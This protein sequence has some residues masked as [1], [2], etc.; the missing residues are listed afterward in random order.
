MTFYRLFEEARKGGEAKAVRD[1]LVKK[2]PKK[3][4][5]HS[6]GTRIKNAGNVSSEEFRKDLEEILN[7]LELEFSNTEIIP[8][9]RNLSSKA[10][11][12]S[13]DT[14]HVNLS[15]SSRK[16]FGIILA[17][18]SGRTKTSTL[19]K[20]GMV[21]FFF[22]SENQYEPFNKRISDS[23]EEYISLLER[24]IADI[25]K[26]GINGLEKKDAKEIQE[27]LRNKLSEYDVNIL[28]SI[29]NAMS[30]GNW[31]RNSQFS[32]YEIRRDKIFSDIKKAGAK[33]TKIPEDKW[34]PM[35][36]ML[37]EKGKESEVRSTIAEV[38]AEDNKDTALSK[39]NRLFIN[40]ID[41]EG[42]DDKAIC[43]AVSLKEAS[44]Q[45]GRAKSYIDSLDVS[46]KTHYNLSDQEKSWRENPEKILKEIIQQREEIQ[47]ILD[48]KVFDYKMGGKD[49]TKF[50]GA[51]PLGKYGALKMAKFF[52]EF[53][54]DEPEVFANLASYGLSLGVN[55][56]FFKLVGSIDG[57]EKSIKT[58]KFESEG[59]VVLYDLPDISYDKK[60]WI[61][62]NP[63]N[64][65][66]QLVYW[67]MFSG[68]VYY[69][70]IQIRSS[71][72]PNQVTQVDVE[73]EE[74]KKVKE[75]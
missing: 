4:M 24:I 42:K 29:F 54:K 3:Y 19:F 11:S 34:C 69:V 72:G 15:D 2:F 40:N 13:F 8:P 1:A 10:Q 56:T 46:D 37:I 62:D 20:E 21:C 61:I 51:N 71:K 75:I 27:F 41:N 52:I 22:S 25:K 55:P 53:A 74:F 45:H 38:N 48:S 6:S 66:I 7:A 44:S 28:N 32:D 5:V 23:S 57:E 70:Q 12:D 31:L 65:G 36:I 9:G 58:E 73:I 47:S 30:I 16:D 67:V 63:K 64:S 59:G 26:E 14:I 50:E 18:L 35:D 68:W 39:L 17:P 60:I 49:T 33:I 43:L